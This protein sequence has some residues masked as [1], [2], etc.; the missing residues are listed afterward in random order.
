MI[1]TPGSIFAGF[2]KL[3]NRGS[4]RNYMCARNLYAEL[5]I[6]ANMVKEPER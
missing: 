6:K 1:H 2:E 5:R 4:F 3:Y